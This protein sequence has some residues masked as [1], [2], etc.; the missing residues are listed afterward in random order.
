MFPGGEKNPVAS[1]PLPSAVRCFEKLPS[2]LT[3]LSIHQISL[4]PDTFETV[5]LP[6]LRSLSLVECGP[7]AATIAEELG[8]ACPG[9]SHTVVS[10]SGVGRWG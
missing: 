8:K 1:Q 6:A 2:S 10:G 9:L 5:A 7:H 4:A 3:D